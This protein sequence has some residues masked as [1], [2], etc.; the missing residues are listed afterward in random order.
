VTQSATPS[1]TPVT[2]RL[3]DVEDA[4][5]HIFYRHQ[6]DPAAAA[7][8]AFPSRPWDAHVAHWARIRADP[9]VVT[10]TILSGDVVAGNIVSF[11]MDSQREVGYWIGR[12]HW[13]RGVASR[14]L[15]QFLSIDSTRPLH[16]RVVSNNTGSIRV[17]E[18][19]GF[20]IT[21]QE[22]GPDG[23]AELLLILPS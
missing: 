13:G 11:E 20:T 21:A 8:A 4:D 6:R 18:K 2:V 5:I 23:V 1:S 16:A 9:G 19:C 15:G 7:M 3:R 22:T 12:E 10:K 14:A 17:L